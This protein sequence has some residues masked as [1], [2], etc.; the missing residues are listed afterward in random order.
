MTSRYLLPRGGLALMVA[1]SSAG[2]G[3]D[4]STATVS[5]SERLHVDPA[6]KDAHPDGTAAHP[7]K[8]LAEAVTAVEATKDWDGTIVA[9]KGR[10]EITKDL[11]LPPSADFEVQAGATFAIGFEVSIHPQRDT[12]V[13]GTE[14]EPV[15]FTWLQE[16]M[17][18]GAF[19]IQEKTSLSNVFEYAVFEHASQSQ[20]QGLNLRGALSFADAGGRV[21]HCKFND[22]EGDDGMNLKR[23]PI[24]IEYSDFERNV[25]DAID[26]DGAADSEIHH[27][28][29]ADNVNDSIDLGEGSTLHAHH[30]LI[31]R[32]GDKGF[33]N[34]DGSAG[35]IDHNVVVDSNLGIGIKDS[36]KPT[37]TNNTF[38][39]NKNG[40]RIYHHVDGFEGGM[41][42]FV[43]NII[44]AS[45]EMDVDF[46]VGTTHINHNCL[47]SV[48]F[49]MFPQADNTFSGGGCDDPLFADPENGDF[50]LM[51][52]AGRWDPKTK[53]WVTDDVTSPCIDAGDP[54][55]NVLTEPEPNGG[56]VDMGNFGGEAEASHTP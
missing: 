36:S 47:G 10:H 22:N 4:D 53:A 16:G 1:L 12:K 23:S 17:H 26:A 24:V 28:Y 21:S 2:C 51:S 5:L 19:T 38:Y 13:R 20:W 8:S 48:T 37:V 11:I 43:N 9:L 49:E 46:Q 34:G 42:T 52:A 45:E 30:N 31:V 40:L 25:A 7:F 6:S 56:R 15:T 35:I 41:G 33:S 14:A 54:D 32:S 18:W 39:G 44:W 3:S 29:F 50:H 55:T 27:C